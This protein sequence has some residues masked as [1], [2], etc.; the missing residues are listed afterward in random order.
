MS[1]SVGGRFHADQLAWALLQAGYEVSLHT[2]LPKHRFAGLQGVR[3]HTH[4]WSEILYRLGGKW[5]FADKADHWKMKTLGRS[6]AKD[7]ESSD[8]LVSWS[9][10]GLEAFRKTSAR[11]ILMRDSSHISYQNQCLAL[12]Y[13]R[14]GLKF[15]KRQFCEERELEEYSLSD[16]IWVLSE[17]AKK[18]FV[19][20]GVPESKLSTVRLGVHTEHFLPKPMRAITL[21]IKAVFFGTVGVRKG[22]H[23][24]LEATKEFSPRQL[25]VTLIGPVER[26]FEKILARYNHYQYLAPLSHSELGKALQNYDVF[27]FPTLEDGFGQTLLQAMAVG[28]VP[29]TTD[30]CG[31]A[32]VICSGKNGF[33]LPAGNTRRLV[34]Q[35]FILTEQPEILE[36]MRSTP[37]L[38]S[39]EGYHERVRELIQREQQCRAPLR[40][41]TIAASAFSHG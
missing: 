22:V 31:A 25:E 29:L 38:H 7:A 41:Q 37:I 17:F 6:L 36:S 15:A 32:E 28:L 24:L 12:E 35:L 5:G 39:W 8:I 3:F 2:S 9:S 23:H 4:L 40:R 26:G 1:L 18:S 20:R 14:L 30:H 33:V 16:R 10:F 27:L 19:D 11:K 21:P 34:E 13:T